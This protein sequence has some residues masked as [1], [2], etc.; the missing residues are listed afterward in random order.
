M[1]T[2]E[3]PKRP[4]ADHYRAREAAIDDYNGGDG[5]AGGNYPAEL[6]AAYDAGWLQAGGTP[7]K[8]CFDCQDGP[9][10]MNCGPARL[11]A[12]VAGV[13]KVGVVKEHSPMQHTLTR[14]QDHNPVLQFVADAVSRLPDGEH[15]G[16]YALAGGA[17][18]TCRNPAIEEGLFE[19]IVPFKPG[20]VLFRD[21]WSVACYDDG[22]ELSQ[23]IKRGATG[24][25][26]V[27]TNAD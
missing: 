14:P 4:M 7:V 23:V 21:Y 12:P 6:R 27:A 1:M 19:E 20:I 9:C 2:F 25:A 18:L 22:C 8:S 24:L 10:H 26:G 15:K 5:Y 3:Q 13:V 11:D 16:F 17:W